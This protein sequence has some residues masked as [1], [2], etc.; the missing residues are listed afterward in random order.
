MCG[1]MLMHATMKHDEHQHSSQSTP[2]PVAGALPAASGQKC[3]H[4]GFPL[5]TGFA[6]CPTCG[7]RLQEAN[8]SAWATSGCNM[9]NVRVLRIATR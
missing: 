1:C 2:A 5:Q 8:C 4:C 7:M 9:E 6:F 3:A